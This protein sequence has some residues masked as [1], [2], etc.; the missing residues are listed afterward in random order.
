MNKIIPLL[1]LLVCAGCNQNCE[2]PSSMA[3]KV[4]TAAITWYECQ[5]P[6]LLRA[7]WNK[8]LAKINMCKETP[9]PADGQKEGPIASVVCPIVMPYIARKVVKLAI[10]DEYK[11]NPVKVGVIAGSVLTFLCEFI[12]L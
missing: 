12:P 5:E 2:D 4:E 7:D 8:E 9:K 1:L 11:C 10:K 6:A 3:S